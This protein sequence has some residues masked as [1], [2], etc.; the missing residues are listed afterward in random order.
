MSVTLPIACTLTSA[1]LDADR[2]ALLPGLAAR[3]VKRTPL[4]EGVRLFFAATAERLREIHAV[5][6]RERACC[7]FL[8]FRVSLM[9]SGASLTLDVT[10]PVGTGAF[11]AA[12]LGS[13]QAA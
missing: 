5:V 10:G 4:P 11:L 13:Y 2:G 6:Q 8:D 9:S 12:L 7:A 3:A 1:E